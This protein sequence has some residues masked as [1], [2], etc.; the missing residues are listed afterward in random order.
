M[1]DE[2]MGEFGQKKRF[3][4][5]LRVEK[6]PERIRRKNAKESST[7]PTKSATCDIPNSTTVIDGSNGACQ[8]ST[9]KFSHNRAQLSVDSDDEHPDPEALAQF[10]GSKTDFL[11]PFSIQRETLWQEKTRSF[12]SLQSFSNEPGLKQVFLSQICQAGKCDSQAKWRSPSNKRLSGVPMPLS[13]FIRCSL[14]FLPGFAGGHRR[15]QGRCQYI[16]LSP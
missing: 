6:M 1:P 13:P 16:S 3:S 14:I 11:T 5:R 4:Q 15:R 9:V 2:L 7:S 8:A 10:L 12:C